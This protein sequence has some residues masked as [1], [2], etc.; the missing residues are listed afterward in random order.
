M[1]LYRAVRAD[2]EGLMSWFPDARSTR[3]WGGPAFRYPFTAETFAED[4]RWR[5][6]DS[7]RL[8]DADGDMLAFGQLYERHGRINLARLVVAPERRGQ[9]LGRRLVALLME[10]GRRRFPLDEF[11]LF[12]FRDNR[13]ARACYESLGFEER[14]WPPGDD[15]I[16]NCV[17]MTR[18]V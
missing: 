1:Q 13:P 15:L 3:V 7:F 12:V 10:E 6:M 17:Y 11:S 14:V 9:G 5:Q 2:I 8:A 16:E 18:P 4:T